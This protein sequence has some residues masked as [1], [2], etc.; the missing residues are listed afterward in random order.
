MNGEVLREEAVR[1]LESDTAPD[2][3]CEGIAEAIEGGKQP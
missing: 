2:N 1:L 3:I